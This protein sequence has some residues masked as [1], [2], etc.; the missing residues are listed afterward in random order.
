[1]ICDISV[2][3]FC[4]IFVDIQVTFWRRCKQTDKPETVDNLLNCIMSLYQQIKQTHG[5]QHQHPIE[6]TNTRVQISVYAHIPHMKQNIW[7]MTW[8]D[9]SVKAF[10]QWRHFPFIDKQSFVLKYKTLKM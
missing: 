3:I 7:E 9:A 5:V 8:K 10:Y 4:G 6:N 1:M 2:N